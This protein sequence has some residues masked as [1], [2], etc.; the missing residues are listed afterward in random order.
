MASN[1]E[2]IAAATTVV[3]SVRYVS[4]PVSSFGSTNWSSAVVRFLSDF[5]A[6]SML[7]NNWID[8]ERGIERGRHFVVHQRGIGEP[9]AFIPL[10]FLGESVAHV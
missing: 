6:L 2:A 9:A 8:L 3:S 4:T 1:A 10:H 5:I 7:D